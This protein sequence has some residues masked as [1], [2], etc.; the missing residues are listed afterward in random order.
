LI[1]MATPPWNQDPFIPHAFVRTSW[2]C[3]TNQ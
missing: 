1:T 3:F 2:Y